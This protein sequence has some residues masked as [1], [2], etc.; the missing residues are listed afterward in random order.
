MSL[1]FLYCSYG[2]AKNKGVPVL[3]Q[4]HTM[5]MCWEENYSNSF[6]ISPPNLSEQLYNP[7]AFTTGK[8][9]VLIG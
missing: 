2:E 7:A 1:A 4:Q 5:K 8:V 3:N 6:L 9:A